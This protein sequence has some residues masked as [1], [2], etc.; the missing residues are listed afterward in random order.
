VVKISGFIDRR[1]GLGR[2]TKREA[3]ELNNF[4]SDISDGWDFDWDDDDE[5]ELN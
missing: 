1:K 4:T 5:D 2:P 3:R